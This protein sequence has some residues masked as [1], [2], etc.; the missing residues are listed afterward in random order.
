VALSGQ[1]PASLLVPA[2]GEVPIDR[3]PASPQ[4]LER[5]G[6]IVAAVRGE[7][8]IPRIPGYHGF[9]LFTTTDKWVVAV[10]VQ[11]QRVSSFVVNV[12]AG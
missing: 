12:T 6:D 8:T 10:A 9:F 7:P 4:E 11:G 1:H 2:R 3:N 5:V